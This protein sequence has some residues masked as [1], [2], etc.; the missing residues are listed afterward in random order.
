MM[1][2]GNKN[3]RVAMLGCVSGVH[4]L[5]MTIA[6]TKPEFEQFAVDAWRASKWVLDAHPPD[7]YA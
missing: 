7:Q 5:T 3:H 2:L 4:T 1:M 6:A